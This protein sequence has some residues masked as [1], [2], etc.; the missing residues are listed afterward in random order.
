M[1]S[2]YNVS[3]GLTWHLRQ[4]G[5]RTAVCHSPIIIVCRCTAEDDSGC[6]QASNIVVGSPR[7]YSNHSDEGGG[8]HGGSCHTAES[9]DSPI[10]VFPRIAIEF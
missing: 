7:C 10:H 2:S 5:V 9:F 1:R 4:I 3:K 8:K 6:S